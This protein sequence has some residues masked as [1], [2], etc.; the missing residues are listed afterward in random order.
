MP[1][2]MKRERKRNQTN[3][4]FYSNQRNIIPSNL[5]R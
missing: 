1:V 5:G 4:D 3:Y 2:Q